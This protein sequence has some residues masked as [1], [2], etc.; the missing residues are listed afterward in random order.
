MNL[1]FCFA[2]AAVCIKAF[3][4]N[5]RSV[6]NNTSCTHLW[7]EVPGCWWKSISPL[8]SLELHR[9]Q[10]QQK[11]IEITIKFLE[12]EERTGFTCCTETGE[13]KEQMHYKEQH[14]K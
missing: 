10:Q 2:V 8:K 3:F 9:Q 11:T 13:N 12:P 1:D 5:K 6:S 7:Q 4:C 14:I